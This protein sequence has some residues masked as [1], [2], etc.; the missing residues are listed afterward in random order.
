MQL[1]EFYLFCRG[2]EQHLHYVY[3]YTHSRYSISVH[4]VQ[5]GLRD[6]FEEVIGFLRNRSYFSWCKN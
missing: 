4:C 2:R 3:N 1:V 5:H 6:R